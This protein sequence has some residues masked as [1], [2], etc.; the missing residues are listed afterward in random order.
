MAAALAGLVLFGVDPRGARPQ[1][2]D[3]PAP[4]DGSAQPLSLRYRFSE[5]YDPNG[6]PSRPELL[7]QYQVGALET[8]RIETEKPQGAPDQ[9]GYS[10]R[11]IYT[12]RPA[13]IGRLGE[14]TDAVR[15]YDRFELFSLAGVRQNNAAAKNL[16]QGLTIWYHSRVGGNPEVISLTPNRSI[17]EREYSDHGGIVNQPFVPL[18]MKVMPPRSARVG[19]SWPLQRQAAQILL[20]QLPTGGQFAVEGRLVKVEKSGQGTALTATIEIS[21]ELDLEEG[22]GAVNARIAFVFEPSPAAP[23][24]ETKESAGLAGRAKDARDVAVVDAKG[25]IA[26]LNMGRRLTLPL[27]DKGRLQQIRTRELVLQR[28][29]VAGPAGADGAALT[30]PDNPPTANEAN[31]WL[32]Y[33]D[34]QRRFHFRHPQELFIKH[35]MPDALVLQYVRPDGKA[36]TMIVGDI[37]KEQDPV[38]DRKWSD[39][40]AFVR[41]IRDGSERR[42]FDVIPGSMGYL[43]DQDWQPLKRRV[44]RYEAAL[45]TKEGSRVYLDAY[46]VL[47]TR[48]DHFVVQALTEHNDHVAFRDQAERMIKSLELGPSTSGQGGSPAQPPLAPPSVTTPNPG[49]PAS[50]VP[51]SPTP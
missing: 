20:G 16:F 51:P 32:I 13:K 22:E 19:D 45:K 28:R 3:Q 1:E 40:Q 6:D 15:R 29:L 24:A 38:Q 30:V 25:Y 41:Y 34:P 48:G 21:G 14:V 47:F 37:P 46:L 10:Y 35:N 7:V 23:A 17:Q 2:P 27:D 5:K 49:R 44:Y 39:P 26:K 42:G 31:S 33:D 8:I 4:A 9:T 12:E 43:P 11:T 18:L 50:A 36:D